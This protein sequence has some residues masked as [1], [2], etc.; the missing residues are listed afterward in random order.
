MRA[1]S[2]PDLRVR[3]RS[4]RDLI[5]ARDPLSTRGAGPA[6]NERDATTY[7]PEYKVTAVEVLKQPP[8]PAY[9]GIR[10]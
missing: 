2:R 7:T 5:D 8:P 1:A 6:S 9:R 3:P 4:T 10:R